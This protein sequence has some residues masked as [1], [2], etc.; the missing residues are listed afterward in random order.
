MTMERATE[1][2]G[3][4]DGRDYTAA[5]LYEFCALI[6]G[7]GVY[8]NE[9]APTATNENMS[10]T[11]GS[12]HA[13]INGV[14]YKN[15]TP[16]ILEIGTADGSL[17]RYD[18]LMVRL[19]LSK[20]E[21]YALIVQ[22]EFAANPTPPA[23]T[24][25]SETWDLKICDI[26]IPAG[27]TKITQDLITDTRLDS[28]VCGVPVFPV[29]HLDLTTFYR[30]VATDMASFRER[31]Q[32]NFAAWV[33]EQES[34]RL[35]TMD[36]LI[37]IVR[38]TSDDSRDSILDLLVQLNELVDGDTVGKLIVQINSAASKTYVDSLIAR[39]V[40]TLPASS[41]AGN[42]QTVPV[43]GVTASASV[44]VSPDPG[45]DSNYAAYSE[46]G[47][48]CVSQGAGTLTFRC[49]N[50]PSVDLVVSVEIHK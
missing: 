20:N 23:V 17:N 34:S 32:A 19:D 39:I 24:R 11:H 36:D 18:S 13:W 37:E 15:T 42:A 9:L 16:F 30:Q 44:F 33:S 49:E 40:I 2:S 10:I 7:N 41:W 12:G 48:R 38:Q 43:A 25:N 26:Y 8:A 22:G 14:C 31:E 28:T 35:A 21:T 1:N 47:V 27:C 6:V 45:D 46:S 29:E 3:F 5:F 4:L 50:T